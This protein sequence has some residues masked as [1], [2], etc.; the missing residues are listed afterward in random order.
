MRP[1]RSILAVMTGLLLFA[2]YLASQYYYVFQPADLAVYVAKVDSAP[3]R[4]LCA[5]FFIAAV[6]LA[7]IPDK[8]QPEA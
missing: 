2:G 1:L 5:V 7:F 4:T 3:I 6:V 8:E